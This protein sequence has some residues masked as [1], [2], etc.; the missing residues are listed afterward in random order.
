MKKFVITSPK[1]SGEINVLYGQPEGEMPGKLQFIDFMK[2]DLN[3]EQINYFKSKLPAL[4]Q[5]D[6]SAAFG[7]SELTIME[8]GYRVSFDMF[9]ERYNNKKNRLR[10]E[11]QWNKLSAA[12]QANAYFKYYLYERYCKLN[13]WYN[14]ALPETYLGDRYWENEWK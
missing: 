9:W 6:I 5:E 2:C 4:Y 1:F 7:K 14:K 11:K 13:P 12:D 3:E 10:A 8:S